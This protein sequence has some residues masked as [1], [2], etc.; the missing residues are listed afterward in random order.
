M[1]NKVYN[2]WKQKQWNTPNVAHDNDKSVQF[3]ASLMLG[4]ANKSEMEKFFNSQD[5]KTLSERISTY[6]SAVHAYDIFETI[7]FVK[8][9]KQILN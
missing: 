3:Q 4:F 6:S 2:T 9:G 5:V 1:R 7:T 8:N